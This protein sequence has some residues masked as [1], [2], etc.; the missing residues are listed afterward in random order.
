MGIYKRP[1]SPY[2]WVRHGQLRES[3]GTTDKHKALL[4]EAAII[5]KDKIGDGK[6]RRF[7]EEATSRWLTE[8]TGK[9]S[10]KSD[11]SYIRWLDK[12]LA[13]LYLDE[14]DASLVRFIRISREGIRVVPCSVPISIEPF[15][16][17]VRECIDGIGV[18]IAVRV[19]VDA[20]LDG[21]CVV[22]LVVLIDDAVRVGPDLE[23]LNGPS[24]LR[25]PCEIDGPGAVSL[26]VERGAGKEDLLGAVESVERDVQP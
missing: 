11:M 17:I 9:R 18:P 15:R 16:R 22:G 20:D 24:C 23:A 4:Y 14:I 10:L 12:H 13:G 3:T 19:Q 2:W 26:D 25:C 7:W 6:Q 1:D 8:N 21:H 5:E